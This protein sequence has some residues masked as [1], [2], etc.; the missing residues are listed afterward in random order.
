MRWCAGTE[1]N[2]FP[3][4]HGLDATI[5]GA[6]LAKDYAF[7]ANLSASINASWAVNGIDTAWQIPLVGEFLPIFT[8][9]MKAGGADSVSGAITYHWYPQESPTCPLGGF[10]VTCTPETAIKPATL[11]ADEHWTQ[12]VVN[13]TR[14]AAPAGKAPLPVWLGEMAEC[15]C[16]GLVN[17]TN[18][19]AGTFYYLAK[20]GGLSEQGVSLVARQTLWASHSGYA[21]LEGGPSQ[22]M[23]GT[24]DFWAAMLFKQLMGP[25]VLATD[26][27]PTQPAASDSYLRVHARCAAAGV[28]GADGAVSLLVLNLNTTAALQVSGDLLSSGARRDFVVTAAAQQP[29]DPT[30]DDAVLTSAQAKLNGEII[31]FDAGFSAPKLQGVARTAAEPLVLPPLSYAFTVLD[32]AAA[33]ACKA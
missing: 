7:F 4:A 6:Q 28:G 31:G 23:L 24:V 10:P 30:V 17:V 20:L 33:A 16:G 9:F 22:G 2:L 14:A 13:A 3:F 15:S 26:V 19:W 32:D 27:A 29:S 18:A 5:S 8:D 21:L 11:A 1:P 25:H 12:V